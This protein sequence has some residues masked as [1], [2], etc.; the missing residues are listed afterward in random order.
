[1]SDQITD[2]KGLRDFYNEVYTTGD[3][4]DSEK[5]YKWIIGL[6]RAQ[7]GRKLLDIA[8]G[9]GWSLKAGEEAGLKTYGLDISDEAVKKAKI[10]APESEI[11]AGDGENLPWPENSFDYVTCLGSL[12]HYLDP[13][14]GMREIRRVLKDDGTALIMLPNSI[15]A[16]SS[17]E[18]Q[19]IERHGTKEEWRQLLEA[20][21]LRVMKVL[22][23]NKYPEF[24]QPGTFKIKSVKKF[25]TV[26]II[27][28]LSPFNLA[29]QFVYICIK[30]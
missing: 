20:N 13:E 21:G 9:S 10:N 17:E 2:V 14:K 26:S 11:V 8:C 25:I 12:E 28:Y 27:R 7:K 16:S 30:S 18:W 1:M 5:L 19:V 23:Y 15:A 24:F 4:R 22:R 3:I 29:Q 6:L